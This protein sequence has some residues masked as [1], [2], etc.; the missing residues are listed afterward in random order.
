MSKI[1]FKTKAK[2]W[3]VVTAA[4]LTVSDEM[5]F[6]I[7]SSG[8]K[9][10]VMDPSHVSLVKL[11]CK[12]EIFETLEVEKPTEIVVLAKVLNDLVRRFDDDEILTFT[13]TDKNFLK[14]NPASSEKQF[15]LRTIES[16]L[17]PQPEFP[18]IDYNIETTISIDQLNEMISDCKV[19]DAASAW[20]TTKNGKLRYEGKDDHG[21]A[22]GVLVEGIQAS[23]ENT[24]YVFEYLGPFLNSIE[25]YCKENIVMQ[26]AT[27]K[28]LFLIADLEGIGIIQYFLAPKSLE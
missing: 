14:I 3:K 6:T 2:V 9:S 1:I 20:L 11:I 24:S 12:K 5:P 10:T 22:K 4:M 8:L 28:P 23:L 16:T 13:L 7:S 18:K 25:K 19:V 15:E 26:L 21:N 27:Q 17:A